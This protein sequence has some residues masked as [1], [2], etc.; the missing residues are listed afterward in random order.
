MKIMSREERRGK[1]CYF[2]GET[3]SVKYIVDGK[4]CCNRCAGIRLLNEKYGPKEQK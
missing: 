1:T 2:C 4:P 3:R